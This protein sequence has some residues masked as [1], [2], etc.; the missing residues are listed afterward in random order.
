MRFPASLLGLAAPL[1]LGGCGL[2]P[3]GES[4]LVGPDYE[5]PGAAS[6]E[7]WIDF[8]DARVKSEEADLG[9]WWDV[10]K[11]PALSK[12]VA[13][14][15]EENLTLRSAAERVAASRA[16]LGVA[17]GYLYPQ[18][19][20]ASGGAAVERRS[21][22]TA[23]S[24]PGMDRTVSSFDLSVG[25]A[26]ELDFW[27]RYRRGVQA[28]DAELDASIA[29]HDDVLVLLYAEVVG[30]YIRYRTYQERLKFLRENLVI[31]ERS[32]QLAED[33]FK[34]GAVTERDVQEARQ[35]LEQTRARL[36]EAERGLR[37]ENNALCVL[38]GAVPRDLSKEL[39]VAPIPEAPASLVVGIP[40]DLLRRRPDVRRAERIA[41][42]RS[43]LIGIA[44][45][46][47]YPSIS[48]LGSLGVSA[49]HASDLGKSGSLTGY[50]GP[51]FRWSLFDY[52]RTA[53]NV[54]AFEAQFR[55]AVYDYREAVLRA[56]GE[57]EDAMA[58]FL[59]SREVLVPQG[60]AVKAAART[61]EIATDQYTQGA[62]DF[63]TLFLF[64]STL[65]EQQD[66]MAV[67][68]GDV[69]LAVVDLYRALGGG[70]LNEAPEGPE[71][72][73]TTPAGTTPAATTPAGRN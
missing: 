17:T 3:G 18:V 19:Q 25:A 22:N 37:L 16:R 23:D 7:R 68:R 56:G 70:W 63:S 59:R 29:D 49:E 36:P 28:A 2:L 5:T 21:E 54:Q 8:Q 12:L 6:A 60:E 58:T 15:R 71:P 41:A 65:T 46:D 61:V 20:G 67:A 14:A 34:A 53:S 24:F 43:A 26:W 11:D 1:L 4:Y 72:A 33:R 50:V 62:V 66:R 55:A 10:F 42:A 38:T 45:A 57:A 9:A 73:A 30:R 47:F 52:G 48:I 39:G 44:E 35:V 64:S 32:F 27:G 51:S 40:A 31:Q 69:A 13:A